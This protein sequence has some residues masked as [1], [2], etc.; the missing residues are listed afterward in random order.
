MSQKRIEI[1]HLISNA[2]VAF[3][4][5]FLVACTTSTKSKSQNL[6]IGENIPKTED[7]I[8]EDSSSSA[9]SVAPDPD[10]PIPETQNTVRTASVW[11]DAIGTDAF[12]AIGFMQELEKHLRIESVHGIGFGCW[13]AM[14]WASE[15][16][17]TY[18]EWQSFK[19][20]TWDVLGSNILNRVIGRSNSDSFRARL[21]SR[22]PTKNKGSYKV[23]MT[24]PYVY[25]NKT[26]FQDPTDLAVHEELWIQ[27]RNTFFFPLVEIEKDQRKSGFFRGPVKPIEF[28]KMTPKNVRPSEHIWIIL[29]N[30]VVRREMRRGPQPD[31][32]R[33]I[34]DGTRWV[35]VL[36]APKSVKTVAQVKDLKKK[37]SMLLRGRKEGKRFIENPAVSTFLGFGSVLD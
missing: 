21:E 5:S 2:F 14:S 29:S 3:V 32:R 28:V 24:C 7:I 36:L 13:A 30:E 12:M 37:R 35:K 34:I 31:L 27:M 18:A 26:T 33:G 23:P 25:P 11:I 16:R 4:F 22:L 10:K 8:I 20:D 9:P 15:N 17:G 1:S 19:W 6:P